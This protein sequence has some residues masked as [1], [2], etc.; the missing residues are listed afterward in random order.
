MKLF[1]GIDYRILRRSKQKSTVLCKIDERE[2]LLKNAQN[3]G[4]QRKEFP[5]Q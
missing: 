1:K 2:T 4:Y 5:N 3:G